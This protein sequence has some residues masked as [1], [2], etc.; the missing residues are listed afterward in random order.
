MERFGRGWSVLSVLSRLSRGDA[1]AGPVQVH[2]EAE[3]EAEEG[4]LVEEHAL[5][6][7]VR[8]ERGAD[9]RQRPRHDLALRLSATINGVLY[10]ARTIKWCFI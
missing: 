5:L 2:E 4:P 8:G 10:N 7:R 9:R 6:L 1:A 3:E